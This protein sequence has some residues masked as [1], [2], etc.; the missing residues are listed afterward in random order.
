MLRRAVHRVYSEDIYFTTENEEKESGFV[1]SSVCAARQEMHESADADYR[2]VGLMSRVDYSGARKK[3]RI[4]MH[5]MVDLQGGAGEM[6]GGGGGGGGRGV[7]GRGSSVGNLLSSSRSGDNFLTSSVYMHPI[8]RV[9]SEDTF[10]RDMTWNSSTEERMRQPRGRAE[11]RLGTSHWMHHVRSHSVPTRFGTRTASSPAPFQQGTF[12]CRS[13]AVPI[14]CQTFHYMPHGYVMWPQVSPPKSS[15]YDYSHRRTDNNFSFG[16]TPRVFLEEAEDSRLSSDST[17]GNDYS[18]GYRHSATCMNQPSGME[19]QDNSFQYFRPVSP[20]TVVHPTSP[21]YIQAYRNS[22]PGSPGLPYPYPV[23]QIK[24]R[25]VISTVN[26]NTQMP[27]YSVSPP[28]AAKFSVSRPGSPG[29]Y[30][31]FSQSM[32][33]EP[34]HYGGQENEDLCQAAIDMLHYSGNK[35]AGHMA[36]P[37]SSALISQ[38]LEMVPCSSQPSYWPPANMASPV[39]VIQLTSHSCHSDETQ[40]NTSSLPSSPCMCPQ[41][42]DPGSPPSPQKSPRKNWSLRKFLLDRMLASSPYSS[43]GSSTSIGSRGSGGDM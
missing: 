3:E 30:F 13:A 17:N 43:L 33:D 26:E 7:L 24:P 23:Q 5:E 40:S 22:R 25:Q 10:R 39:P 11:Q 19:C 32:Q 36:K 21:P 34:M 31:Q 37:P 15:A 27:T 18:H 8:Q 29:V 16:T 41:C 38:N 14:P 6:G 4:V 28:N 42:V 9:N 12:G 35:H 20:C 1:N 2:R